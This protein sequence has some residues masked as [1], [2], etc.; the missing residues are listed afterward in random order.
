VTDEE[1]NFAERRK[2]LYVV[3]ATLKQCGVH[4]D[5]PHVLRY[6]IGIPDPGEH[7]DLLINLARDHIAGSDVESVVLD[8]ICESCPHQF[9]PDACPAPQRE[10]CIPRR[11][12]RSILQAICDAF[13]R[14]HAD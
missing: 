6:P 13:S 8:R 5:D 1:P 14:A 10:G 9:P 7:L 11:Y 2:A 12:G 3:V 4:Q